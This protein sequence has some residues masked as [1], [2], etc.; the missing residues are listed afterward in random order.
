MKIPGQKDSN[1]G[2]ILAAVVGIMVIRLILRK[3]KV[4]DDE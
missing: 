1:V 2:K 3:R 4:R